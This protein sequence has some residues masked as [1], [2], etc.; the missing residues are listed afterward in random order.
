[1]VVIEG[2]VRIDPAHLDRAKPAMEKMVLASRAEPGCIDYA[3]AFDLMDDGLI[4]V[5]ERWQDRDSLKAHF[6]TT[7][8]AAWRAVWPSLNIQDRSLRLYEA[9]PET[10]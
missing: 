2:T 5:S 10:I 1:M 7:H 3:Y 9:D 8:M 4:R 6:Q